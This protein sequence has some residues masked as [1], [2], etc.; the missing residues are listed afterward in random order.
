MEARSGQVFFFDCVPFSSSGNRPRTWE[1][2]GRCTL[3]PRY[4]MPRFDAV[5][6]NAP[7][8]RSFESDLF[9]A[10]KRRHSGWTHIK[11]LLPI[12]PPKNHSGGRSGDD[13]AA[14]DTNEPSERA[15][16]TRQPQRSPLI[17]WSSS[18]LYRIIFAGFLPSGTSL[19]VGRATG[20]VYSFKGREDHPSRGGSFHGRI[21]LKLSY[22]GG[23]FFVIIL[24]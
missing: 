9:P 14:F 23:V 3:G 8:D 17:I 19:A 11:P 10:Y 1:V 24:A 18:R 2:Q 21:V 13:G 12:S 4:C 20:K 22:W 7:S 6:I 5:P 15:I 16:L